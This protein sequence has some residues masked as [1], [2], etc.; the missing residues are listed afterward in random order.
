MALALCLASTPSWA[1]ELKFTTQDFPPFS[2]N[3]NGVVSGPAVDII[4]RVCVEMKA[5]C[6]FRLLPWSRAQQEVRTGKANGMFVI[7]WN[8]KRA[9]WV[10]FTPPIMNTEYGIFVKTGNPLKFAELADIGG[11]KVGVY[12]PSNTSNSLNKIRTKMVEDGLKAITIDM[13]PDDESGFKKLALGRIDAVFSNR[14]V[15]HALIAKLGLSEKIQYAGPQRKLKYFIGFSMENNDKNVL[16]RF[17]AA[18]R[19]LHASGEVKKILDKHSMEIAE[20]N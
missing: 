11:Y 15:G 3:T 5:Q 7:G 20:L 16:D 4:R 14:D 6:S 19:K 1:Q 10:H 9:K 8:Q 17:D 13:R 2:Y 12:G 18:Y